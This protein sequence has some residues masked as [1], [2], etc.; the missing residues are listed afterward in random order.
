VDYNEADAEVHV[1]RVVGWFSC[2]DASAVACALTLKEYPDAVIARIVIPDEHE[3]AERFHVD[4]ERWYGKPILRLQDPEKRSI[5]DVFEKRRYIAG[6][7]GAP[8]TGELKKA[9]RFAFQQPDDVH[10]MGYTIDEQ[11]RA[12]N[13]R[14]NNFELGCAFPLIE[15]KLTKGDCHAIVREAGIEQHAMYRLGFENA[16]CIGCVKGG[17]GYWNRIKVIFPER[18]WRMAELSRRLGVRL[19]RQDGKR[20]FL[21]E[22]R[23]ET[24]RHKEPTFDCSAFCQPAMKR[25][26]K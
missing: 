22:L 17:A 8:C 4:C 5:Y 9:V 3:D 19:V 6:I 11:H 21:D 13:F 26:R 2:G 7:A 16:N 12:D 23:P 15:Q 24:G 1:S 10:V 20:I 25:L 18:F 14:K